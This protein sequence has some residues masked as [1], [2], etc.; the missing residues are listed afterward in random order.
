MKKV[1]LTS[2][3][4]LLLAGCADNE[5]LG[6]EE[7]QHTINGD[8]PI[9]FTSESAPMTRA[10]I[11]GKNAALLLDK[12]YIV[13]GTKG[14][15]H[16]KV[17]DHYNINWFE[18]TK[19]S[20]ETN[21]A[22]WEYVG[23]DLH[24]NNT[25]PEGAKQW[26]KYWD[27][28]ASQYDFIAFSYGKAYGFNED[29]S[30]KTKDN[31]NPILS[32]IDPAN[33][34]KA[35]TTSTP[36]YTVTGDVAK[37]TQTYVADLV[38]AYKA[39]NQY[40]Q[41]V[42]PRFH[43]LA[44]K[45]R[46]AIYETVAGYAVKDVKFYYGNSRSKESK[47]S[48]GTALPVLYA[49]KKVPVTK[50]DGSTKDHLV[51]TSVLPNKT[52]K[53][54][55]SVY[56]PTVG[57]ANKSA[58]DYN[59]AHVVF[60]P[61]S[62]GTNTTSTLEFQALNY[63]TVSEGV[64]SGAYIG[65]TSSAATYAGAAN[66]AANVYE[67]V[68]PYGAGTDLKLH[69]DYTL[70]S[71]DGSGEEIKV[72]DASAL[73]PSTYTNWQPN[74]AYTYIFKISKNSNGMTG[75]PGTSGSGSGDPDD[76]TNPGDDPT[77]PDNLDPNN[78]SGLYPITFDA[79]VMDFDNEHVQETITTVATPSITTYSK[80]VQPTA[81]SEYKAGNNIYVSVKDNS[82]NI[83][84]TDTNAKLY[85]ATVETGALQSIDENSIANALMNGNKSGKTWTVTDVNSGKLTVTS[86]TGLSVVT[87]IAAD[88]APDGNAVTGSFAKFTPSAAGT[89]VFEYIV[90]EPE[91][92]NKAG[93]NK[94]HGTNLSADE[95]TALP[96]SQ[97]V[98]TP[99]EKYYKIIIV[100]E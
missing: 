26:I 99:G 9:L 64:L 55:I 7:A 3:S 34:G 2:L 75:G 32:K 73:V 88:D 1:L 69:V 29:G 36:V 78:P 87:E 45:V 72:Y 30:S 95:F 13:F 89:Y 28:S 61:A 54:K 96:N 77:D 85:T 22:D 39:D 27:F 20:T 48:D 10:E 97:K 46:I 33:L 40:N 21:V 42:T 18:N 43:Q 5:F 80:G 83:T 17:F 56:F 98:K 25:L 86:T 23:Q 81:N 49:V 82:K 59:K 74:Y 70:V 35:T 71:V 100:H 93:Y 62:T 68:F 37:L 51:P 38:T 11:T 76:Q 19:G 67:M 60:E 15:D 84:L 91:F 50:S 90:A 92:Y 4:A 6:S 8:K 44:S 57:Y 65:Q 66:A 14:T 52:G 47:A 53:G 58:T 31:T 41:T 63:Q 12:N 94:A 16:T 24:K 79:Y